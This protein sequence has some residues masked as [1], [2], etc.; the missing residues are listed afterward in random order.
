MFKVTQAGTPGEEP[1]SARHSAVKLPPLPAGTQGLEEAGFPDCSL[2]GSSCTLKA[3]KGV[4]GQE[5]GGEERALESC[6]RPGVKVAGREQRIMSRGIKLGQRVEG[7][8]CQ[9]TT[10]GRYPG[11]QGATEA[12][13]PGSH[14]TDTLLCRKAAVAAGAGS[15][16]CRLPRE[17]AV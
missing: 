6:K 14:D 12:L 7:L 16:G 11:A 17:E 4:G 5:R 13:E 9:G 10:W 15:R 8:T 2:C 1:R 3:G